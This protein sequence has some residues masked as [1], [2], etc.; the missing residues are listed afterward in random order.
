MVDLQTAMAYRRLGTLAREDLPDVATEALLNGEDTVSLRLLAGLT[1]VEE[2]QAWHLFDR[3]IEEL[4]LH[5]PGELDATRIV[6]ASIAQQASTGGMRLHEAIRTLAAVCV[7]L[8]WQVPESMPFLDAALYLTEALDAPEL[9]EWS[10]EE[11][12]Q[13]CQEVV[14][15]ALMGG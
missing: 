14:Q 9:F 2:D 13:R 6:T 3:A 1:P 8:R 7:R 4:G 11:L 15:Q 12:D 10:Q 5:P